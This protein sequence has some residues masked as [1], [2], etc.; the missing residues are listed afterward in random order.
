MVYSF[1]HPEGSTNKLATRPQV[2]PGSCDFFCLLG[3]SCWC[4]VPR[5]KGGK[6]MTFSGYSGVI[7]AV[8]YLQSIHLTLVCP[9]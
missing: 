7:Q 8:G 3:G 1:R 2:P 4:L 5:E 6:Q 9:G